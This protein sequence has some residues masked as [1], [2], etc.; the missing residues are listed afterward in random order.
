MKGKQRE[1]GTGMERIKY[2]DKGHFPKTHKHPVL[3]K[4]TITA[5]CNSD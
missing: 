3:F 5:S 1:K 2:T 4:E